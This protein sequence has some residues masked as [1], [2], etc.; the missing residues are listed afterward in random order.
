MFKLGRH[1]ILFFVMGYLLSVSL[2]G[3]LKN[4]DKK[5]PQFEYMGIDSLFIMCTHAPLPVLTI[6]AKIIERFMPKQSTQ[7][8]SYISYCVMV[9]A[10]V[11]FLE[12]IAS[13]MWNKLKNKVTQK[14]RVLNFLKYC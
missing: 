8:A 4:L 6:C 9:F 2:I 14:S 11:I 3:L 10:L 1:P 7:N 13:R 5:L 12:Y